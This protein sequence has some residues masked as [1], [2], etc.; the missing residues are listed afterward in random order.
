MNNNNLAF[1]INTR[2]IADSVEVLNLRGVVEPFDDNF[3]IHF[4]G[5]QWVMFSSE[6]N[7]SKEN[8]V[9][10]GDKFIDIQNMSMTDGYRLIVLD[11]IDTNQGLSLSMRNFDFKLIDALIN[12]D[13]ITFTGEGD[14]HINAKQIFAKPNLD[15]NLIIPELMLNDISYGETV[16]DFH[17]SDNT[18]I[19]AASITNDIHNIKVLGSYNT[20]EKYV[21]AN[22]KGNGF[23]MKF[24][25]DF[26][27][28]DGISE[29]QGYANVFA[30][31]VGP[32]DDIKINGEAELFEGG[33]K[34][35]YLGNFIRFHKQKLTINEK[36]IGFDGFEIIDIE[37]NIGVFKGGLHHDLLA[38]FT[39]ELDATG[40]R[41][42]G[43][44]TTKKDNALYHGYGVGDMDI[45]FRGPF[46]STDIKVNATTGRETVLNIPI[47]YYQEGYEN[48]F[49]TFV[50]STSHELTEDGFVAY[51][52]EEFKIEGVD[53]EMNLQITPDAEV[54]IIF[55]EQLNDI[56]KGRG[57]GN[58]RILL[59]RSG[60][61]DI[62]GDYFVSEGEYLFTAWGVIAKPFIVKRG[63]TITWTGDPVNAELDIDASYQ[64]LRAPLNIFLSE[65]LTSASLE[66]QDIAK[67]KTDVDLNLHLGGSLFEPV[68]T[69]DLNF[70]NITG[71]L[72]SYATSKI[73]TLRQNESEMNNQVVGLLIF[74]SFLPTAST[75]NSDIY[76][77]N[78]VISTG[79]N[80]LSEMVSNQISYLLSGFLQEALEEN[81]FISGIDFDIGFSKNSSLYGFQSESSNFAPDEI[82]VNLKNKFFD[83]RW[84]LNLGGNFVRERAFAEGS[85]SNNY[86]IGDFV[87]AYYL[88]EDK[89][90]K[91]RVYGKY[92]LNIFEER[93]QKYGFGI[94]YRREFGSLF[95]I[96]DALK[97]DTKKIFQPEGTQ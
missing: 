62:F 73:N 69:F 14:L 3:K 76:S 67:E 66:T 36:F 12:Y 84:E 91:L 71:E 74:N 53:V 26:I 6:W 1:G 18:V 40:K 2:N 38:D 70:P 63:G 30:D 27:I 7:F 95:E 81:G 10:L 37:N 94:S 8:Q 65:L 83:D 35:N 78:S 13:K 88:T 9:I 28:G 22:L 57:E 86:L 58:L 39:I 16:L 60:D 19:A 24:F 72:R 68:V 80:T 61:F 87:L 34:I 55:N 23:Q 85:V 64:G 77:T 31:V 51:I 45:K 50:D 25:Q 79:Y 48:S 21:D 47:T 17:T 97:A 59:K 4:D 32:L 52:P 42:V 56:I 5:A 89:K 41:F 43:L 82:E 93:E 90:L 75:I 44:N 49:I 46:H 15:G 92:D 33:V 54:N 96:Q 29:T 11:D 20:K